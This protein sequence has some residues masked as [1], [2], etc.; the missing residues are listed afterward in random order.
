[1]RRPAKLLRR[2][3][4]RRRAAPAVVA[5]PSSSYAAQEPYAAG[6]RLRVAAANVGHTLAEVALD[7][8]GRAAIT[9]NLIAHGLLTAL[10]WALAWALR[11]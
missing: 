8:R 10:L 3:A 1:L 7:E 11:V 5:R 6:A 9:L 2:A 4:A